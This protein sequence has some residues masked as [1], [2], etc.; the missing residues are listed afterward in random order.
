MFKDL[1]PPIIRFLNETLQ[2]DW[3][4]KTP[5]SIIASVTG[6]NALAISVNFT[7]AT[8]VSFIVNFSDNNTTATILISYTPMSGEYPGFYISAFDST[9]DLTTSATFSGILV[10]DCK[11]LDLDN[12]CLFDTILSEISP[13]LSIV[14]CDCLQYYKGKF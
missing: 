12:T 10:C 1:S 8:N 2:I 3:S 4:Q 6:L 11:S 7:N 13:G 14:K 9:Q 5:L